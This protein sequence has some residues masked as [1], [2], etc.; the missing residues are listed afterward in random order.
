MKRKIISILCICFIAIQPVYAEE[1]KPPSC[2]NEFKQEQ[3]SVEIQNEIQSNEK[4]PRLEDG[5]QE[6]QNFS[7][8]DF[9]GDNRPERNGNFSENNS[10]PDNNRFTKNNEHNAMRDFETDE[11]SFQTVANSE[12]ES[13]NLSENSFMNFL[14]SYSTP[15]FSI[16]LL[17]AAFIFVTFYKRKTF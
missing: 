12:V 17:A 13:E 3:N 11:N 15:L 6:N 1:K 10:P 16:F 2:N 7:P 9:K 14:K 8:P 4:E 5:S